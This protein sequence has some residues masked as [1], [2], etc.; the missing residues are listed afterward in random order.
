MEFWH[1]FCCRPA[2]VLTQFKKSEEDFEIDKEMYSGSLPEPFKSNSVAIEAEK[3]TFG[4]IYFTKKGERGVYVVAEN[5]G[6]SPI[7]ILEERIYGNVYQ[8]QTVIEPRT[9]QQIRLA[10][11]WLPESVFVA[12]L[13][14][15]NGKMYC[16]TAL[17][18]A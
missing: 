14:T 7:E 12:V 6:T 5:T 1:C 18:P 8:L 2:V 10:K 17:A 4:Q 3:L 11:G 13:I 15:K 9:S 16:L